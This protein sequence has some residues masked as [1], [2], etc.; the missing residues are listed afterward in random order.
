[1]YLYSAV[2]YEVYF[3]FN[4]LQGKSTALFCCSVFFLCCSFEFF[5]A[6]HFRLSTAV[7][8][9]DISDSVYFLLKVNVILFYKQCYIYTAK[10]I[11]R[12][13]ILQ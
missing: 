5:I 10:L 12:I 8:R 2:T 3:S 6:I 13:I 1:M 7:V 4:L 9:G 11:T